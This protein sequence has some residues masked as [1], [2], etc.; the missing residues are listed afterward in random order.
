[1]PYVWT[2]IH[3]VV[4]TEPPG[5]MNFAGDWGLDF[6]YDE[7]NNPNPVREIDFIT[8][9]TFT[10]RAAPQSL[11]YDIPIYY[12]IGYLWLHRGYRQM[13]GFSPLRLSQQLHFNGERQ[14][15]STWQ[16]PHDSS[17]N[18]YTDITLEF[19]PVLVA[20]VRLRCYPP[21]I[22]IDD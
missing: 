4:Y 2:P 7:V 5:T 14:R 3:D 18:L 21:P 11:K 9:L 16:A 1:M 13:E 6:N 15:V 10:D 20:S 8:D 12:E 17:R 19:N 22:W